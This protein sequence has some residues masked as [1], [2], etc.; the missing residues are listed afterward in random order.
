M[1]RIA[2]HKPRRTKAP[3]HGPT[4]QQT[5]ALHTGVKAWRLLRAEALRRDLFLCRHC[6]RWGDQ[7]DHIDG[8]SHNNDLGNLQTLCINCHSSKTA[9]ENSRGSKSESDSS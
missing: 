5:R 8:N 9:K 1:K 4:R 2:T 6:G 7:V 3:T